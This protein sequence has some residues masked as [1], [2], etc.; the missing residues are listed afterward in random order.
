MA[1]GMARPRRKTLTKPKIR[2]AVEAGKK[3]MAV[4]SGLE[5]V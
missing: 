3:K 5:N 1:G 4:K 2:Q